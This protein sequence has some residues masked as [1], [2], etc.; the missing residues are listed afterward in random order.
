MKVK[1]EMYEDIGYFD[2]WAVRDSSDKSFDSLRLFH[3]VKHEDAL[4]FKT[5]AEKSQCAVNQEPT[6]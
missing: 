5:L 4:A 3:F 2:M 6:S 1:W